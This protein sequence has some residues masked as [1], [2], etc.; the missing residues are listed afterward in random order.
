MPCFKLSKIYVFI[1]DNYT[2]T[3]S[4]EIF[5]PGLEVRLI[6]IQDPRIQPNSS[7]NLL[8]ALPRMFPKALKTLINNASYIEFVVAT[9]FTPVTIPSSQKQLSPPE[10]QSSSANETLATNIKKKLEFFSKL[11]KETAISRYS[12]QKSFFGNKR[13]DAQDLNG[14]QRV[15]SGIPNYTAV[16][17]R[18]E[19]GAISARPSTDSVY[20]HRDHIFN[21]RIQFEGLNVEDVGPGKAWME[22]FVKS[23]RF[24]DDGKTFP[25]YPDIELK[26]YLHRYY[27]S[28][29]E[30]LILIK[31]KW[32]PRD[33]FKTKQSIPT[34]I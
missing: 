27:G 11:T 19:Q 2:E 22:K 9:S 14:V 20:V 3:V 7:A 34:F 16:V 18:S 17:I 31:R 23:A 25:N 5:S 15:L 29:L 30:K 13:F 33:Y 6:H 21:V 12:I 4:G 10:P 32:D 24:M 28:N 26:D 1:P 8:A